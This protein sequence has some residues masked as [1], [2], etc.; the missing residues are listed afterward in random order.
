MAY[1]I[2]TLC[3]SCAFK[4][5]FMLGE[6][7]FRNPNIRMVPALNRETQSFEM[8]NY[9]E[10]EY[11]GKY[12][13]YSDEKLKGEGCEL[14]QINVNNFSFNY[15]NNYCPSCKNYSWAFHIG[16]FCS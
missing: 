8:T 3:R 14:G 11:S 1:L 6:G 13:F 2:E 15:E 9:F 4:N 7:K 5:E 12:Y 10:H 16:L